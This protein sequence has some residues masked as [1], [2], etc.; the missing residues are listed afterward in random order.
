MS[1]SPTQMNYLLQQ[2]VTARKNYLHRRATLLRVLTTA[3]PDVYFSNGD[4][5]QLIDELG[6]PSDC[7]LKQ[8][9]VNL[10]RAKQEAA[11]LQRLLTA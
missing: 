4:V 5:D 2:C 6:R 9:M 1:L 8:H 7:G 11:H 3:Y 10:V